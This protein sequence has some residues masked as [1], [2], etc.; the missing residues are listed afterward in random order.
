MIWGCFRKAAMGKVFICEEGMNQVMYKVV[1]KNEKNH[2]LLL[3]VPE[4]KGLGYSTD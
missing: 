3:N 1:L 4:L 2:F